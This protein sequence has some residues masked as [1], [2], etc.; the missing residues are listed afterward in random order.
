VVV[1]EVL[2]RVSQDKMVARVGGQILEL[3]RLD[4]ETHQQ[5]SL[6]RGLTEDEELGTTVVVVVVVVV[7]LREP[8]TWGVQGG[9]P[10]YLAL[11]PLILLVVRVVEE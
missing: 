2:A 11:L 4:W 7:L 3:P 6:L 10:L 9:L 8:S 5:L 1:V